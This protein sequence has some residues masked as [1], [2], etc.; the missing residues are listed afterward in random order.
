M[1]KWFEA[2]LAAVIWFVVYAFHKAFG[3]KRPV[4]RKIK[5]KKLGDSDSEV[6]DERDSLRKR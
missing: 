1:I 3:G 2:I 6:Q 4:K 5:G